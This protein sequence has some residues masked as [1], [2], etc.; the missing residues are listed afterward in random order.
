MNRYYRLKNLSSK[1]IYTLKPPQMVLGRNSF[2]DIHIDSGLLSRQHAEIRTEGE[3][4]VIEDLNST[5]GTFVNNMR[6]QQ[7][8]E[9]MHGD[10]VT[11]GHDKLMLIAPEKHDGSTVFTYNLSHELEPA[12]ETEDVAASNTCMQKAFPSPLAW[13]SIPAEDK[14]EDQDNN[15]QILQRALSQRQYDA[16]ATPALLVVRSGQQQ[17]L[18]F[19]L[20]A[21]DDKK[22]E[23]ELGRSKFVDVVIDHP[24]VSNNHAKIRCSDEQWVIS[25]AQSTNGLK[26]N[27]KRVEH[28]KCQSGDVISLGNLELIFVAL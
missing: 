14:P 7:A 18:V 15:Q 2:S 17:G 4:I 5:N 19:E 10:V 24:T 22:T 16:H 6:I 13:S 21:L 12:L 20:P 3:R 23:W 11:V 1:K 8:T 28:A 25:D 9:L 26:I 27:K